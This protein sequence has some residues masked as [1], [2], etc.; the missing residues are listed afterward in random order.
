[1]VRASAL[2]F[3]LS[4]PAIAATPSQIRDRE[5]GRIPMAP[6][7]T[8][9]VPGIDDSAAG[10]L[11]SAHANCGTTPQ[12]ESDWLAARER[13]LNSAGKDNDSLAIARKTAAKLTVEG[14][15]PWPIVASIAF[16]P[17]MAPMRATQ[18]RSFSSPYG[19]TLRCSGSGYTY[20]SRCSTFASGVVCR[21][22]SN[23]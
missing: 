14:V 3:F 4:T 13:I 12:C 2:I 9:N 21:S 10:V 22:R 11:K 16:E 17:K 7:T 5:A 20:E 19:S 18:C 8:L 1:M 23:Y 15:T 6:I